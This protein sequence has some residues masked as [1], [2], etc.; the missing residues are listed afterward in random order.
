MPSTWCCLEHIREAGTGFRLQGSCRLSRADT[1]SH[2]SVRQPALKGVAGKKNRVAHRRPRT[3][4]ATHSSRTWYSWRY[5]SSPTDDQS[6]LCVAPFPP[7]RSFRPHLRL[8]TTPRRPVCLST[9]QPPLRR[10]LAGLALDRV[11]QHSGNSSLGGS[12]VA[13][14]SPTFAIGRRIAVPAIHN[15]T[16]AT[17][18]PIIGYAARCWMRPPRSTSA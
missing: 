15:S 14:F 8:G 3:P 16:V 2:A 17:T 18:H 6:Q 11:R 13:W 10:L 9:I 5:S 4:E 7:R 12:G 1:P